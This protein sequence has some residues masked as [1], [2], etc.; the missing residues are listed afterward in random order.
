MKAAE[1][2]TRL[3]FKQQK[4]EVRK[5]SQVSLDLRGKNDLMSAEV[6]RAKAKTLALQIGF[7]DGC[8][9][10]GLLQQFKRK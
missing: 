10:R 5:H 2:D 9:S 1:S 7:K 3:K 8:A 4:T 6:L